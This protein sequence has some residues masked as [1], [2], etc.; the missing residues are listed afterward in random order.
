M[1]FDLVL[2]MFMVG[3]G[4]LTLTARILNW[5]AISKVEPMKTRSGERTGNAFHFGVYTIL[6]IVL[7]GS[8]VF[9][10]LTVG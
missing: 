2:G 5:S 9:L 8:L 3:I 1:S 4:L 7:G 6:P 10:N